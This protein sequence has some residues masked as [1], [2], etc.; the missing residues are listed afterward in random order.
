MTQHANGTFD[1]KLTPQKP[2]NPQAESAKLGRMSID[3][4]FH[5]DREA[6]SF[7]E[8]LAAITETKGSAGYVAIERI[9]GTLHG[10]KGTFILQHNGIKNR[11][12]QA[13]GQLMSAFWDG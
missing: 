8:M 6:V 12:D 13:S 10:R 3:K 1:V 5:G 4:H 9:D 2:D 7:G 11:S